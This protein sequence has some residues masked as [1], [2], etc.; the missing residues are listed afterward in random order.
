MLPAKTIRGT[1]GGWTSFDAGRGSPFECSF[2]TIINVEGRESR[3][4]TVDEVEQ[5]VREN[6]K[7]GVGRFFISDDN[8]SGNPDWEQILDRLI[9]MREQEK[10][11]IEFMVQV[12]TMCHRLPGFIEK[13]GRAG[14]RR[15][16]ISLES[17]NPQS[18]PGAKKE[19]NKIGG[20]RKMLL[21]W[22]RAGAIV[23]AGYIVGFPGETAE[24]V[25]R[26]IRIIK[27][28]LA[29][30]LLKPHCLTALPGSEDHQ[31]L[32]RAGAFLEPDLNKYDLEH[33]TT[34]HS[35]MT[36]EEWTKLYR[37]T[38][39][40]FY[41]AEHMQTVLRRAA[42]TGI[43]LGDMMALLLWFHFCIVYEKI[44]PLQGGYLRRRYR[45]DRRPGMAKE[46]LLR[47]HARYAA[48]LLYK[49]VRM[50]QLYLRF[51][52]FTKRLE[53]DR[54]AQNYSDQALTTDS[55]TDASAIEMMTTHR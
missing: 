27:K 37:D 15:V 41:T 24:S 19:Q 1:M 20:C 34:Q 21:E 48:D 53:L 23:L 44:D 22:K 31:K 2:C 26:D 42:A 3:R 43:P 18:L 40:E 5:I 13:A 55:E 32:Y 30:D 17:I 7:Q 39:K 16:F 36:A 9:E 28:E 12:D 14:V 50:A 35:T 25:L 54:S 38:W 49:H 29:I 45:Q 11:N 6:L 52:A 8:F 51:R 4:R 46:G 10:L 33:V 47:F